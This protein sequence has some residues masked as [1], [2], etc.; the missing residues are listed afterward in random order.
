[1]K[2]SIKRAN[3]SSIKHEIIRKL[4]IKT[5]VPAFGATFRMTQELAAIA[6]CSELG[7]L[8]AAKAQSLWKTFW[9]S[10]GFPDT[11]DNISYR[12]APILAAVRRNTSY[13][14]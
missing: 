5:D 7:I 1:M 3:I 4:A 14:S 9:I 11:W 13:R 6:I 10:E 8:A 2:M 12:I